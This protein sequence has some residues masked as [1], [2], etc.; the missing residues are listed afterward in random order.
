M[1]LHATTCRLISE[2]DA[3]LDAKEVA[4]LDLV[5]EVAEASSTEE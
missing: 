2:I 3:I 5:D 4:E 1:G